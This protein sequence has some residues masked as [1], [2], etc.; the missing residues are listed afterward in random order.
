MICVCS[1]ILYISVYFTG[2]TWFFV[3]EI[4][5]FMDFISLQQITISHIS[6]CRHHHI[7]HSC[8]LFSNINNGSLNNNRKIVCY[9]GSK[10]HQKDMDRNA[11]FE[12]NVLSEILDFFYMMFT[13]YVPVCPADRTSS[14]I[15]FMAE[16]Q[17]YDKP[18]PKPMVTQSMVSLLCNAVMVSVVF[19][20]RESCCNIRLF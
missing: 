12:N 19:C 18:L 4:D 9:S 6:K 8:D 11:I 20:I 17:K 15:Q 13:K 3:Y 7:P 16:Y 14:L 1:N 2:T 10:G 5:V